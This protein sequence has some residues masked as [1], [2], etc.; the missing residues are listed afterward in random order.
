M[1]AETAPEEPLD[2]IA[3]LSG[4][5][6]PRNSAPKPMPT[7]AESTRPVVVARAASSTSFDA[8]AEATKLVVA[9]PR[10]IRTRFRPSA[11]TVA[12][13]RAASAVGPVIRP[14]KAVSIIDMSWE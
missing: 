7:A 12:G 4:V 3:K 2:T 11:T 5:A 9:T 1:A 13:P 8:R 10:K 6:S 14:T